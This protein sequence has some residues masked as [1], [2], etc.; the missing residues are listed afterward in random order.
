MF[1]KFSCLK[2]DPVRIKRHQQKWNLL[3]RWKCPVYSSPRQWAM[4]SNLSDPKN[5]WGSPSMWHTSIGKPNAWR[6]IFFSYFTFTYVYLL[7][8]TRRAKTRPTPYFRAS[9]VVFFSSSLIFC[10]VD[11]FSTSWI[12]STDSPAFFAACDRRCK[13]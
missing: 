5:I 10:E 4:S 1:C 8:S 13:N 3:Y 9:S 11:N 12:S 2:S 6:K 7:N